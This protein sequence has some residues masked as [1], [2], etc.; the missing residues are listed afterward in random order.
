MGRIYTLKGNPSPGVVLVV[1]D[2][3]ELRRLENMRKEFVSNV[4]HELKT[5]LA[6]IQAYTEALLDGAIDDPKHNRCFLQSIEE[7]AE[8]LHAL[9][10]DLL[11]LTRIESGKDAFDIA[12]VPVRE[13]VESC[14]RELIPL[15]VSKQIRLSAEPLDESVQV[16]A[17]AEGLGT[18]LNNLIENAI[19]YTP[20]GGQVT[21]RWH[22]TPT[23]AVLEVQDSGV[24][25]AK[26]HQDRI[27]ERFYRV[28][29]ARSRALG[30]T[31]LGLSIVKHLALEFGGHVELESV[32]DRG[33]TFS[34]WLPLTTSEAT[35]QITGLELT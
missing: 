17:D 29:K 15:A 35:K 2:V 26:E 8:R 28:D 30:G 14:L 25:I 3:T 19:N 9:I 21:V 12:A 11:R 32:P 27:F 24:G 7:Q 33:S 10:L 31:G 22:T 23:E 13:T 16:L 5:P 18:I 20:E 34:V 1:Q 4:S 6:S